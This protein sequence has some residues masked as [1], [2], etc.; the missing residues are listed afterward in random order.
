MRVDFLCKELFGVASS[1]SNF[2]TPR[3]FCLLSEFLR[4][5]YFRC[6]PFS[7]LFFALRRGARHTVQV[8]VQTL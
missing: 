2:R 3:W 6:P 7:H 8:L 4:M 5:A 1:A